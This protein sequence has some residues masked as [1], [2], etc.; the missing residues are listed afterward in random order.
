MMLN[1]GTELPKILGL[2][3]RHKLDGFFL[4]LRFL[5][6]SLKTSDLDLPVDSQ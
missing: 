4:I 2:K 1:F 5:M 6:S 3:P